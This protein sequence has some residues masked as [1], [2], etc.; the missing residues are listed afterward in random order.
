M[1]HRW[2]PVAKNSPTG[3]VDK[4]GREIWL[5][6]QI[7]YRRK[8]PAQRRCDYRRGT[9]ETIPG[10]YQWVTAVVTGFGRIVKTHYDGSA[11]A[12][13]YIVVKDHLGMIVTRIYRT[14]L[15]EVVNNK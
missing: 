3:R 5:G 10:R 9:I 11:L 2:K 12:I 4:N 7:K 15:I 14:D 13:E 1:G 6:D 8:I